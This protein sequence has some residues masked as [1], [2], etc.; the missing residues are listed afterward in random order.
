MGKIKT[1]ST[2]PKNTSS[3]PRA[4]QAQK[5]GPK[6]V[7][8]LQK[9]PKATKAVV[10]KKSPKSSAQTPGSSPAACAQNKGYHRR[11]RH[12]RKAEQSG[13]IGG[14]PIS[15]GQNQDFKHGAQKGLKQASITSSPKSWAQDD[16][17]TPEKA[18]SH[19]GTGDI[20]PHG[21]SPV[22]ASDESHEGTGEPPEHACDKSHED[23]AE[24]SSAAAATTP[25]AAKTPAASMRTTALGDG[26]GH[27][28]QADGPPS[29]LSSESPSAVG[30]RY[31]Q[32]GESPVNA[33]DKSHEGTGEKSAAAAATTPA[34]EKK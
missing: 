7:H 23:I 16:E 8:S 21:K 11:G 6:M 1:S 26:H 14:S 30:E 13:H 15:N 19:E 20:E 4:R 27:G 31:L 22:N 29:R 28:A 2:K 3:R 12:G 18:R 32:G 9:K 24:K 25:A 33:S 34:A 17:C 5:A 10:L